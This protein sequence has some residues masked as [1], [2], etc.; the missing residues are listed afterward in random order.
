MP[1]AEPVTPTPPEFARLKTQIAAN[2]R[3]ELGRAGIPHTDLPEM[4]GLHRNVARRRWD[5][6]VPYYAYEVAL[7]AVVL[8][9]P[10]ERLLTT[11]ADPG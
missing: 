4:L 8:D 2:V 5:G 6:E 9:I 11:R 10:A 3:A 7:L 1:K